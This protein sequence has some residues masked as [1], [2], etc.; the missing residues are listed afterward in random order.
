NVGRI[1]PAGQITEFTIPVPSGVHAVSIG[2]ITTGPDG[3][4]WFV[5]DGILARI[6]PTGDLT[7]HV[8]EV[9]DAGIVAGPDGNLWASGAVVDPQTGQTVSGFIDRI[10]LTGSIT[11][12][13]LTSPDNTPGSITVGP[14][15]NLWFTQP[16]VD[17]IG[18]ITPAGQVSVFPVPTEFSEPT[19]IAP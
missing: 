17:Q 3:N 15:G 18:R 8:A 11:Q 13:D 9:G 16:S 2:S 6:S 5:H 12:L 14:D 4:L 7:D 10:S 1:T 19:A